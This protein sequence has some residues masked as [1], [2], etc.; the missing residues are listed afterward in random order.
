MIMKASPDPDALVL[1]KK[2]TG[3]QKSSSL[4][5]QFLVQLAFLEPDGLPTLSGRACGIGQLLV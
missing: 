3:R 5:H 1:N 2:H 4:S